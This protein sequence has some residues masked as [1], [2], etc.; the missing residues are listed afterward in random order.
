M[1]I[2]K[3][4]S[5]RVDI[6]NP[7][8]DKE[9]LGT[10]YCH[11][12]FVWQVKENTSNA[13][14]LSGPEYPEVKP[15]PFNGQGIPEAFEISPDADE[16]SKGE[17]A[18]VIGVGSVRKDTEDGFHA[19]TSPVLLEGLKWEITEEKEQIQ[20][21]SD[22]SFKSFSYSLLRIVQLSNRILSIKT[23]LKNEGDS[24]LPIR[25]FTHPFFPW[26]PNAKKGKAPLCKIDLSYHLPKCLGFKQNKREI[27]SK[28]HDWE[29]GCFQP[30]VLS[31][32]AGLELA[33]PHHLGV[34]EVAAN[35]GVSHMPIWANDKTFSPEPY[36]IDVLEKGQQTAWTYDFEFS[37]KA[38]K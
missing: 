27:F 21:K 6:L 11:G 17:A 10:R 1:L 22:A 35:Y 29:K 9:Y 7:N 30:L 20:F 16:I 8:Q 28:S 13:N 19:R 23:V 4:K 33:I 18:H 12:G 26:A 32:N 15:D 31:R 3:S 38:F 37:L 24:N 2:L 14:W 25:V 34:I 5:L 36:F